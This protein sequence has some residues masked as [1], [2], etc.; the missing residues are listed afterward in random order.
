MWLSVPL[1]WLVFRP[2]EATL[3]T[4]V[5]D[6]G[7]LNDGGGAAAAGGEVQ[8]DGVEEVGETGAP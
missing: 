8:A 6:D 1:A 4:P 3:V 5:V 7:P 2:S